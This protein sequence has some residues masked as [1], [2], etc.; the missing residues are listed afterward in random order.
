MCQTQKLL[1]SLFELSN[2]DCRLTSADMFHLQ[3]VYIMLVLPLPQAFCGSFLPSCHTHLCPPVLFFPNMSFSHPSF[4]LCLC[5]PFFFF[6][7]FWLH[8]STPTAGVICSV[9]FPLSKHSV[10]YSGWHL[11]CLLSYHHCT[12]ICCCL[13][14]PAVPHSTLSTMSQPPP[15]GSGAQGLVPSCPLVRPKPE[16][17]YPVPIATEVQSKCLIHTASFL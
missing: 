11:F 10:F 15:P 16:Y 13:V 6:S 17:S 2:S 4:H 8:L 12:D 14:L 7:L 3:F 5:P 1:S 9:A